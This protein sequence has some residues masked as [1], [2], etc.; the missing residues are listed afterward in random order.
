MARRSL[1]LLVAGLLVAAGCIGGSG[2]PP[3]PPQRP[4]QLCGLSFN[5]A[6]DYHSAFESLGHAD[7]GWITAD[8]FVPAKLPDGRVVWWMSDTMTGTVGGGNSVPSPVNVHDSTV[9]QGGGCLTPHLATI[10]YG[11]TWYWP[12]STVVVGNTLEV[13]SYKVVSNPNK[14]YPYDWDITGTSVTRFSLP[15]L[16]RTAG[17]TDVHVD[18]APQNP[19]KGGIVPWGIRSFYNAADGNVYLY[20]TTKRTGDPFPAADAWVARAPFG[21]EENALEYFTN[22]NPLDVPPLS[23]VVVPPLP[24]WSGNFDCAKPMTFTSNTPMAGMSPVAQLSVAPS[25]GSFRGTAFS[26]DGF[27]GS[28]PVWAWTA[29]DP[30]GP[31]ARVENVNG[32]PKTIATFAPRTP[33]QFAYDARIADLPAG[34]GLTV[35]YGVN[36]PFNQNQDFTLYRGEFAHPNGLP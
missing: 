22:P 36:D 31:W 16:Q 29:T 6:G 23:C 27:T 21:Q 17:P 34:T 33:Q 14:A 30:Q 20:G 25:N 9:E 5:S 19:Y 4:T 7:T 13:F 28:T 11:S 8:G 10:P 24:T 35:V 3:P 12:G 2:I 15:S 18:H 32:T 1:L 26:G